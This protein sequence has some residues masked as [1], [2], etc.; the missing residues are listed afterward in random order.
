MALL[1]RGDSQ[2]LA[3]LSI[4]NLLLVMLLLLL[5][6]QIINYMSLAEERTLGC[7]LRLLP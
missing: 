1:L 7:Q 6:N 5:R 4:W 3:A 2:R